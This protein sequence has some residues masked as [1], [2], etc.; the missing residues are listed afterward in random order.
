MTLVNTMLVA[1]IAA[2]ALAVPAS[3]QDAQDLPDRTALMRDSSG[4]MMR[5]KVSDKAH[6]EIMKR[7]RPL[8]SNTMIYMSGGKLY[9]VTDRKMPDGMMLRDAVR[10]NSF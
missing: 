4:K 10:D 1:T 7:A 9:S 8:R 3:A 2:L 6:A 5:M